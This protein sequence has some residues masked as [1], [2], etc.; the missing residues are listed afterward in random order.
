MP[1]RLGLWRGLALGL[2]LAT[3]GGVGWSAGRAS[4]HATIDSIDP[5]DG[6]LLAEA[7]TQIVVSFSEAITPN[8]IE[9]RLAGL[10][11]T[12]TAL[13]TRVDPADPTKLVVVL[14]ALRDG[15]YQ[16]RFSVRD[17]EDL[18]EV[19][20]RSSFAV[21]DV[22]APPTRPVEAA[23]PLIGESIGRW[24]FAAGLALVIGSL[25]VRS[26]RQLVGAIVEP[27]CS[28][29]AAA[30]LAAIVL[31]RLGVAV[32]RFAD[33]GVG[34]R[35]GWSILARTSD[36]QRLPIVIA[37][38]ACILPTAVPRRWPGLDAHLGGAA[39]W[40]LR[41]GVGWVGVAWLAL[42][43]AWG[44][45]SALRG[46]VDLELA[47]AKWAHLLGLGLWVGTLT[48]AVVVTAGTRRIGSTL[49]AVEHPALVGAIL[50]VSSGVVLAGGLV[51]S[52]TAL[53][54]TVFGWLLITKLGLLAAAAG[55][56]LV[57]RTH[58]QWKLNVV[59]AGML[60]VIV[61]VGS[62]MAT[63]GPAVGREFVRRPHAA[64]LAEL[65]APAD[66][67]LVRIRAI[68]GRPGPNTLEVQINDTRR[69]APAAIAEI[70][71]SVVGPTGEVTRT[72]RP[73]VTGLLLLDHVVL[74]D[75]DN[76]TSVVVR[77]DGFDDARARFTVGAETPAYVAPV[78]VSSRPIRG[79]ARL[80]ALVVALAGVAVVR[81]LPR[82]RGS[83]T[84][85]AGAPTTESM[86]A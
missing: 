6:A 13:D 18:H 44:D 15:S 82:R 47:A 14:P 79:P 51:A 81:R 21:G 75:G 78:V 38:A 77:R 74:G 33:L 9:A 8:L 69:P 62:S 43:A 29:I 24:V 26:R 19:T 52:L 76:P 55:V 27:R 73:D 20:G 1:A 42:L 10:E 41:D 59:E 3:V 61:A 46:G 56:G 34:A 2:V 45:H 85:S 30:G 58:R 64:V 60:L 31:G 37:A 86:P 72:A 5:P 57:A 35:A 36:V 7:P 22:V 28:R 54:S 71:V 83:M 49:Q 4:A 25:V 11:R 40:K 48:V 84:S 53:F 32:S 67:L 17:A 70:T 66:D 39:Q 23:P 63:S 65:S 68:P 12:E 80:L 50:T 16:L